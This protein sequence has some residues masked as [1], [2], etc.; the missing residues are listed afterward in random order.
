[1]YTLCK[2]ETFKLSYSGNKANISLDKA[3]LL[4]LLSPQYKSNYDCVETPSDTL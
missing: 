2:L 3:Q 4:W 1:M